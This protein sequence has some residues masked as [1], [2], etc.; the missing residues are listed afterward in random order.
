MS[1]KPVEVIVY[2]E[3]P[4]NTPA[5][6]SVSFETLDEACLDELG[7]H[8]DEYIY[9]YY[10]PTWDAASEIP[11]ILNEC[12]MVFYEFLDYAFDRDRPEIF[13]EVYLH[14]PV[15]ISDQTRRDI[16]RM[17]MQG[18]NKFVSPEDS[19]SNLLINYA[20]AWA[21]YNSS[22]FIS[23]I[24]MNCGAGIPYVILDQEYAEY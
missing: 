20:H 21:L 3:Q 1:P 12:R 13:I 17:V 22:Y 14:S 7:H 19:V 9:H 23:T 24:A 18:L 15:V 8:I 6:T 5:N 10:T 2:P 11:H 16:S 4:Q